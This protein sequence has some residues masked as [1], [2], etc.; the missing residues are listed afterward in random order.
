MFSSGKGIQFYN[1][2]NVYRSF[3]LS[4]LSIFDDSDKT[5][6]D[7]YQTLCAISAPVRLFIDQCNIRGK[8]L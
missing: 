7:T 8:T 1:Q 4:G 2:R 5:M 6:M 3:F